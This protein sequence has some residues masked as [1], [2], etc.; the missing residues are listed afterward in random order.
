METIYKSLYKKNEPILYHGKSI[1]GNSMWNFYEHKFTPGILYS[2]ECPAL[3]LPYHKEDFTKLFDFN[4]MEKISGTSNISEL[5]EM[6]PDEV[7][8]DG[9]DIKSPNFVE[10]RVMFAYVKKRLLHNNNIEEARK[11][12]QKLQL[13]EESLNT[14]RQDCF[15]TLYRLSPQELQQ[16]WD[17]I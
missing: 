14:A 2:T 17:H 15:D 9:I 16:F 3:A 8:I 5:K 7:F 4:D 6:Y 12:F 10:T 11:A 13:A 1:L